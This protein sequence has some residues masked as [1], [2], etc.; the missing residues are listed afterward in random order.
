MDGIRLDELSIPIIRWIS[1]EK[2]GENFTA[3]NGTRVKM[4][5]PSSKRERTR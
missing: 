2:R 5:L 3:P 4:E 1:R